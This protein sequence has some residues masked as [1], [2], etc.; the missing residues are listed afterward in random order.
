MI[1]R[2]YFGYHY[3][4][5]KGVLT[6]EEER[7]LFLERDFY[8]KEVKRLEETGSCNKKLDE[9]NRRVKDITNVIME[10]NMAIVISFAE[11]AKRKFQGCPLDLEDFIQDGAVKLQ[12]V[13]GRFEVSRGHKFSTYAVFVLKR[14]FSRIASHSIKRKPSY[15]LDQKVLGDPDSISIG[16][17]MPGRS[18]DDQRLSEFYSS[19]LEEE[20]G[21]FLDRLSGFERY[22]LTRRFGLYGAKLAKLDELGEEFSMTREG[23]R[24]VQNRA[25]ERLGRIFEMEGVSD[26]FRAYL[27][28]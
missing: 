24:Q 22:V 12:E 2:S 15:S 1:A 6:P 9:A 11:R 8:V 3:N 19:I 4:N 17:S 23:I 25:I 14:H 13:I 26:D 28:D 21:P 27:E 5:P 18:E 7:A 16:E 10:R 20:I